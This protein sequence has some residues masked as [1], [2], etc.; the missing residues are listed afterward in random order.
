MADRTISERLQPSLLDR[1]T[2]HE[3]EVL[4]E[5]RQ[6]R[7]INERRLKEILERDLSWLLNTNN[8][9]TLLDPD[10]MP[11]VINSTIN[12]GVREVAGEMSSLD[13]ALQIKK[14]IHVAIERFEPRILPGSIDVEYRSDV[15]TGDAIVSYDIRADMWAQPVPLELF[16]RSEVNVATGELKLERKM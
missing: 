2:D 6:D 4:T 7:V 15:E 8:H 12:Y 11:N 3:P 14:M 5:T 10:A 13:R 9:E 1:L 16:L